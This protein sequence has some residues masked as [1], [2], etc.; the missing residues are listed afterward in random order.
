MRVLWWQDFYSIKDK[1]NSIVLFRFPSLPSLDLKISFKS[2]RIES[3]LLIC[4]L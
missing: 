2:H 3:D 4:D 1:S